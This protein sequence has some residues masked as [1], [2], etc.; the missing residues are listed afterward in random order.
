MCACY[1]NIIEMKIKQMT[2]ASLRKDMWGGIKKMT[3]MIKMSKGKKTYNSNSRKTSYIHF[4][5]STST[6]FPMSLKIGYS[7][8]WIHVSSSS[9]T[10]FP[11]ILTV[12]YIREFWA[13]VIIVV[14]LGVEIIKRLLMRGERGIRRESACVSSHTE[15]ERESL[16]QRELGT[17]IQAR[18]E[19]LTKVKQFIPFT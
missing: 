13:Y 3:R 18:I 2:L 8:S 12:G 11:M 9:T 5:S 17:P 14:I 10:Y 16:R 7:T 4:P 6:Y 1:F 19:G 15:R